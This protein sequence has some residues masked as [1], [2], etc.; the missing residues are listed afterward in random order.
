LLHGP[1]AGGAHCGR[2]QPAGG[3]GAHWEPTSRGGGKG[4]R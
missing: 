2:P 4:P 3:G 1:V